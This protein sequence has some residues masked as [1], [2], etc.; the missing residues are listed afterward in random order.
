M[1]EKEEETQDNPLELKVDSLSGPVL[2]IIVDFMNLKHAYN[3]RI[4]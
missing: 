4:E 1:E 3:S 2:S